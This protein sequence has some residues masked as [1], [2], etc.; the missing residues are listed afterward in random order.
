MSEPAVD[1]RRAMAERNGAAILDATERLLAAQQPL[2]MVAVAAEAGV[3]RPTLYA[4]HAT[5]SAVIEA[6]V[7]RAID[8]SVAAV[9]AAELDAGPADEALDRMIAASW[10][11]LATLDALARVAAEHVPAEHVHRSHAPLMRHVAGLVERGQREG[12]FRSD[13]PVDWLVRTY[14]ALV[15]AA[16]AYARGPLV[17]R[18]DALGLL[19]TSV[20]ALFSAAAA[21]PR[22]QR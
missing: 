6:A 22:G 1:H 10:G 13:L 16:D 20:H 4:H 18:T 7:C 5:L 3:S 8:V 2:S 14:F 21:Q 17:K 15:H 19:Q 9:E 11:R 12:V